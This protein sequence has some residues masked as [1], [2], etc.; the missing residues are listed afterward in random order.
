MVR[1]RHPW[2]RLP[3]DR[4]AGGSDARQGSSEI[5]PVS[6]RRTSANTL[7]KCR[8][9]S[10]HTPDGGCA[11]RSARDGSSDRGKKTAAWRRPG[12]CP[13]PAPLPAHGGRCAARRE[14]RPLPLTKMRTTAARARRHRQ[15][16]GRRRSMPMGVMGGARAGAT[17]T[18]VEEGRWSRSCTRL[19]ALGA[20]HSR[21]LRYA[22]SGD[23]SGDKSQVVGYMAAAIRRC[24]DIRGPA[25]APETWRAT[26]PRGARPPPEPPPARTSAAA[27]S[28]EPARSLR[29]DSTTKDELRG[30]LGRLD[31]DTPLAETVA[32][33][34]A[35]VSDSDPRFHPV[36]PAELANLDVEISV[37]T[38]EREIGSCERDRGWP[39]RFD[40][41]ARLSARLA[42]A[43]GRHRAWLGRRDVP[44][45][46]VPQGRATRGRVAQRGTHLDFRGAGIQRAI[47]GSVTVNVA[48]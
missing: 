40:H 5:T 36:T 14:Q 9:R 17:L 11:D 21:V 39:S 7:S 22:D 47:A 18:R 13:S 15:R 29:V 37:P 19:A 20:T 38:P 23:V 4:E 27:C 41:R 6:L 43:A 31:V 8:C 3:V 34:A 45:A 30:C 46:N 16:P 10:S 48:P 42:A 12:G 28:T 24:P 25:D 1:G 32:D 2:A 26:R 44:R 35:V 33:L